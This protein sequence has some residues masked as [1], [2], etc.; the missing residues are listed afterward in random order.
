[1]LSTVKTPAYF[2]S[3]Q[4]DHIAPWEAT[5]DGAELL[6]GET[7]FVL[8]GSG[9]IAG[10]INPPHKNKY[11]FEAD[12]KKYEG[13]WWPHWRKSILNKSDRPDKKNAKPLKNSA[14]KTKGDAP[15]TYVLKKI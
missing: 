5:K 3:T 10:V 8:G 9:H 11:G 15:G 13:S 14:Y 4:D 2:L 12:G 6:G 7:T 1:M